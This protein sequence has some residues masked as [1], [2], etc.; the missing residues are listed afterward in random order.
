MFKVIR[1]GVNTEQLQTVTQAFG[2]DFDRRFALFGGVFGTSE[3]LTTLSYNFP[4]NFIVFDIRIAL[5]NYNGTTFFMVRDDFVDV[6]N[7]I[8][9]IL[10]LITGEFSTGIINEPIAVNSEID[11]ECDATLSSAPSN[12][13]LLNGGYGRITL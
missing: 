7:T 5:N 12:I 11:V 9:T 4:F 6:P 13:L 3:A 8:L 1:R 2:T 10:T